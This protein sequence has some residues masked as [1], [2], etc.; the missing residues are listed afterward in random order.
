[1]PY[2]HGGTP[3][4]EDYVRTLGTN[5]DYANY[6]LDNLFANAKFGN[7]PDTIGSQHIVEIENIVI[8]LINKVRKLEDDHNY[9]RALD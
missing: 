4:F 9:D 6:L 1:M 3:K 2:I 8:E 5:L 7:L